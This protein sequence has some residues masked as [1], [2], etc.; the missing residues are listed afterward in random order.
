MQRWFLVLTLAWFCCLPGCSCSRRE[1]AKKK[2]LPQADPVLQGLAAELNQGSA[3]E[4]IAAAAE[5]AKL[6][7]K[8]KPAAGQLCLLALSGDQAERTAGLEALEKVHPRLFPHVRTLVTVT[9]A[10]ARNAAITEIG[11]LGRDG[12]AAA[13]VVRAQLKQGA[14]KSTCYQTLAAIA[15]EAQGTFDALAAAVRNPPREKEE[16]ERDRQ[17]TAAIAGLGEVAF[18]E[19]EQRAEI[20]KLLASQ[21]TGKHKAA[22]INALARCGPEAGEAASKIKDLRFNAADPAVQSAADAALPEIEGFVQAAS[23]LK[24]AADRPAEVAKCAADPQNKWLRQLAREKLRRVDPEVERLAAILFEPR[25]SSFYNST[26]SVEA[27]LATIQPA[28]AD[29]GAAASALVQVYASRPGSAA[30]P[31]YQA[32]VRLSPK[33]AAV[34]DALVKACNH[35]IDARRKP[36]EYSKVKE[37]PHYWL[38]KELLAAGADRPEVQQALCKAAS[39]LATAGEYG[40]SEYNSDVSELLEQVL[41]NLT[42]LAKTRPESRAAVVASLVEVMRA[43]VNSNTPGIGVNHDTLEQAFLACEQT[44]YEPLQKEKLESTNNWLPRA[45]NILRKSKPAGSTPAAPFQV[46]EQVW[47][48]NGGWML[49]A[50]VVEELGRFYR[51]HTLSNSGEGEW[52]AVEKLHKPS[53]PVPKGGYR[54]NDLV[55]VEVRGQWRPG[56]ITGN[57]YGVYVVQLDGTKEASE[58]SAD[59]IRPRSGK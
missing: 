40:N 15:P 17:L 27:D 9:D 19:P 11:K 21:L 56:K 45:V 47:K 18:A 55:E 50:K 3:K 30:L 1:Q 51:I 4:R 31:A 14:D 33:S 16:Y 22:V 49:P 52:V 36:V 46:G 43:R 32:L 10:S 25:Q 8:A 28:S 53:L 12:N 6:G 5:A 41:K 58:T 42:E 44:A 59:E 57:R 23:T 35:H 7:E 24:T 13:E 34:I 48:K 39:A 37:L 38:G 54:E 26:A 20:V 2:E 29:A